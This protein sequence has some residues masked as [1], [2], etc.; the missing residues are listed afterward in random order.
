MRLL[1][2]LAPWAC[3]L[4]GAIA[5][6]ALAE[7]PPEMRLAQ[8]GPGGA[9]GIVNAVAFAPVAPGLAIAVKPFDD[10]ELNLAIQQRLE[11]ELRGV[12]RPISDDAVLGLWFETEVIQG[13]FPGAAGDLGRFEGGSSGVRFELNIWSSSRDSILGGR[14]KGEPRRANVF[15]INAI[16]RD[17]RSGKTL[18]Q[19]DAFC[20]M[21]TPDTL[22]IARSMIRP[23]VAGLGRTVKGEPFDIE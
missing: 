22:R 13:R 14:R 7:Y 6:R 5:G 11:D 16:L 9:P 1:A 2:T 21:L 10:N 8:L 12:S 19:G 20:E 15:H 4:A 17:G 23:L 18:W 3:V